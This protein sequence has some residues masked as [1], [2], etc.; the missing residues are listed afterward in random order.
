MSAARHAMRQGTVATTAWLALAAG[1][2]RPGSA[3]QPDA[4]RNPASASVVA[5]ASAVAVAVAPA[6]ASSAPTNDQS[7]STG[8]LPPDV[9]AFKIQRDSCDHFR[10]E[11]GYNAE[12]R[13][14]LARALARSCTGTDQALALL[15]QRYSANAAVMTALKDYE[16]RIE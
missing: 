5:A 4:A 15:R 10:G 2:D 9:L 8:A 16:D 1:C 7:T 11:D 6:V 14:F 13:E 12:R 3:P